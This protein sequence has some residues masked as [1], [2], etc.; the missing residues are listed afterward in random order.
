MYMSVQTTRMNGRPELFF[1]HFAASA[2]PSVVMLRE[3]LPQPFP[4]MVCTLSGVSR[5]AGLMHT[6][7]HGRRVFL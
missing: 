1:A 5:L 2:F 3:G 4:C 6:V 7:E